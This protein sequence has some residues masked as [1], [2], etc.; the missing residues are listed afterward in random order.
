MTFR[1]RLGKKI[2]V[3]DEGKFLPVTFIQ[4][5]SGGSITS[6]KEDGIYQCRLPNGKTKRYDHYI[7]KGR[8][9]ND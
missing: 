4:L 1:L 3:I 7:I 8:I 5:I 9:Y 6:D 2:H